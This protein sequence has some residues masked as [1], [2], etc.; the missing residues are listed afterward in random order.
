MLFHRT[1]PT[2]AELVRAVLQGRKQQ[3][4]VLVERYQNLVYHVLVSRMSHP[5]EAED[6][7]QETFLR[8]FRRLDELEEP[9]KFGPWL[10]RIAENLAFS[11]VRSSRVRA[12]VSIG[13]LPASSEDPARVVERQEQHDRVWAAVEGLSLEHREVV[14]L[15]YLEDYSLEQVAAFLDLSPTAVKG[16]LY[17]ARA[18][19]REVLADAADRQVTAAVR[20]RRQGKAFTRKVLAVLPVTPW[21]LPVGQTLFATSWGSW[22]LAVGAS[23]GLSVLAL[24]GGF[25]W[26]Q[27]EWPWTEPSLPAVSAPA[28]AALPEVQMP[29]V[30][31]VA[32][33]VAMRVQWAPAVAAYEAGESLYG[34]PGLDAAARARQAQ[35]LQWGWGGRLEWDFEQGDQGWQARGGQNLVPLQASG[36]VLRVPLEY[37]D[38][39]DGDYADVELISPELGY[40]AELFERLEVRVRLVPAG[41]RESGFRVSWTTPL[42]RCF[43]GWD[44]WHMERL[45]SEQMRQAMAGTFRRSASRFY[46]FY[47]PLTLTTLWQELSVG[48]LCER[49]PRM[50]SNDPLN[51]P[52]V[53]EGPLLDLRLH[54][55]LPAP[56]QADSVGSAA[57]PEALEI[58]RIA[59]RAAGGTL[60]LEL[61]HPALPRGQPTGQWLGPGTLQPLAQ[62]DLDW[63]IAGDLDGDGDQDLLVGFFSRLDQS[64]DVEQGCITLLNDGRGRFTADSVQVVEHGE[65]GR[66]GISYLD[67][68]DVNHDGLM[69]LVVGKGLNTQVFINQGRGVMQ[70][71]VVWQSEVYVGTGDVD[72]DGDVD[73]ATIL[74]QSAGS[75]EPDPTRSWPVRLHLNDGLGAFTVRELSPPGPEGGWYPHTLDD[76]DRDGRAELV[77]IWWPLRSTAARACIAAGLTT[78]GWL[79]QT[80]FSFT[81]Q[82][83][84]WRYTVGAMPVGYLG[85]LD[86]DGQWDLGTPL[87]LL[88]DGGNFGLGM[89]VRQVGGS[90]ARPWLP[91]EVH[92]PQHLWHCPR[93]VPQGQDL[94]KD[95]LFDPIFLDLN[96]RRGPALLVLRGQQGSW[97]TVEG[98]YPLP[99]TPKGWTAADVDGDGRP[100]LVVVIQSLGAGGLFVL[101][102]R[103]GVLQVAQRK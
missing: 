53:W 62:P 7:A 13:W 92:L 29:A 96:S 20:A 52:L 100:D 44:P 73:V 61:P 45:T 69:D 58:E 87:G 74:H 60:E 14:L 24:V 23:V 85:D 38:W 32:D 31:P 55:M 71:A 68:S 8:A 33:A 91:R 5:S 57:R 99:A 11:A 98:R 3:F 86:H 50:G 79:H 70:E 93:L 10:R 4:G 43:P 59:L 94:D 77:W 19:L 80:I 97:P 25:R 40:A 88:S 22:A 72:G 37:R 15:Y 102:N 51:L 26:W 18:V 9:A 56:G 81:K 17:R 63:P 75:D 89:E 48:P 41:S 46:S 42:N 64:M 95:G 90:A 82:P 66:I 83:L 16:R 2:D 101:P 78:S 6:L 28:L 65:D 84:A 12:E 67:G 49:S 35:A 36:G 30:G 103:A 47:G 34:A 76:Y 21:H 27:G 54:F 1:P 39:G